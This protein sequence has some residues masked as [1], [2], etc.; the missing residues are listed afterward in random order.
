[1]IDSVLSGIQS[2]QFVNRVPQSEDQ[3]VGIPPP[4]DLQLRLPIVVPRI[5]IP[6]YGRGFLFERDDR[7][8][9]LIEQ[10]PQP[11]AQIPV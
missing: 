3:T 10:V 4:I 9:E 11:P 7:R 5:E 6:Q 8:S 1:M 2:G